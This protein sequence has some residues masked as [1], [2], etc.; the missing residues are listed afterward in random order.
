MEKQLKKKTYPRFVLLKKGP[1]CENTMLPRPKYNIKIWPFVPRP[2]QILKRRKRDK[3]NSPPEKALI[4]YFIMKYYRQR[5][6][7][8]GLLQPIDCNI[9]ITHRYRTRRLST[10]LLWKFIVSACNKNDIILSFW[11]TL[12]KKWTFGWNIQKFSLI[13][14]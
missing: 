3:Q 12:H 10:S 7:N 6:I 4:N 1:I 9:Y 11:W 5:W 14:L 13:Y 2:I 8:D